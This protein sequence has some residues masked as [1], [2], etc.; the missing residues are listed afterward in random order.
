MTPLANKDTLLAKMFML[1]NDI[2][3]QYNSIHI[4]VCNSACASL[5]YQDITTSVLVNSITFEDGFS[6]GPNRLGFYL[7]K[8]CLKLTLIRNGL[9]YI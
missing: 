7:I 1:A 5:T 9:A 3:F 2:Q 8:R 4:I 6:V